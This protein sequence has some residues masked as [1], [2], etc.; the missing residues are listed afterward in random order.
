MKACIVDQ[1]G[2]G[3][4]SAALT[5][6]EGVGWGCSQSKKNITNAMSYSSS[7]FEKKDT[8]VEHFDRE[9]S[10]L[11]R[12]TGKNPACTTGAN[13]ALKTRAGPGRVNYAHLEPSQ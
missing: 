10:P 1:D 8:H 2:A 9:F 12:T 3:L 11:T 4:E 6:G 5:H 13:T 7:V